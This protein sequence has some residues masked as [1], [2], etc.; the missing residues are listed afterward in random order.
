[1]ELKV[2][3]VVFIKHDAWYLSIVKVLAEQVAF[4]SFHDRT[5][6]KDGEAKKAFEQ[7]HFAE[8]MQLT[9]EYLQNK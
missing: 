3:R 5:G 2:N 7:P 1:M 4:W 6:L 9:K 8:V